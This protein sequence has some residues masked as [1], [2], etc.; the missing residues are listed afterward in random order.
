MFACSQEGKSDH[1]N[2][3]FQEQ[4][5]AGWVNE[6]DMGRLYYDSASIVDGN[7]PV[8]IDNE[9]IKKYNKMI[10]RFPLAYSLGRTVSLPEFNDAKE[11]E[12]SIHY[13]SLNLDKTS[14]RIH[15][16][17]KDGQ[18]LNE[19]SAEIPDTEKWDQAKI[20]IPGNQVR[21][22]YVNVF[23]TSNDFMKKTSELILE[24]NI[25]PTLDS[26]W[27]YF[28]V[29]KLWI[30]KITIKAGDL[31]MAD[32][33]PEMMP[34]PE[35]KEN[36]LIPLNVN[37]ENTFSSIKELKN[38]K[39]I[40]IG[41]SAHFTEEFSKIAFS[42]IKYRILHDNCK[43]VVLEIPFSWGLKLNVFVNRETSFGIKEIA[44]AIPSD[45]LTN[46]LLWLKNYNQT[47]EHKV[48]LVG[49]DVEGF[50]IEGWKFNKDLLSFLNEYIAVDSVLFK[51][52]FLHVF[53]KK[54]AEAWNHLFKNSERFNAILGK[55]MTKLLMHGLKPSFTS[56][57]Q[58][59]VAKSFL[60]MDRDSLMHDKVL[61]AVSNLLRD[62]ETAV[63][64]AHLAHTTKSAVGTPR[65]VSPVG[66]YLFDA[67]RDKYLSIGLIT[68]SE[69]V[70][71]KQNSKEPD[72]LTFWN[73]LMAFTPAPP[74]SLEEA[75]EK[76]KTPLFYTS[77]NALP[78]TVL[79]RH[80]GSDIFKGTFNY[81]PVKGTDAFIFINRVHKRY[82][83][84][85]TNDRVS[86]RM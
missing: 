27:M 3:N 66:K 62:D 35:I 11:I 13:K 10:R 14:M 82:I 26:I 36:S 59:G 18:L 5:I 74:Y 15:A 23:T 63:V 1:Y 75:C 6:I 31:D 69:E 20:T 17:N 61:I 24:K 29:Q 52:V 53:N 28:P 49:M 80:N 78:P 54:Y 73:T 33:S 4:F 68:Y 64:Y 41:E 46:F 25:T 12:I 47:V 19:Y 9:N 32:F 39:I 86:N 21:H 65:L 84:Q 77:A 43:L 81:Y 16:A 50:G 8:C 76:T 60:L 30:N 51:P 83:D 40:G 22:L 56:W 79:L 38:K 71:S 57:L 55:G 2:L 34:K 45:E 67:Y 48:S 58:I 85:V 42:L 72:F 7:I 70:D 44:D 37:D